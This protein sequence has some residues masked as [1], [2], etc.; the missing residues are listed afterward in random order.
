MHQYHPLTVVLVR[1]NWRSH[2]SSQFCFTLYF[3]S[4]SLDTIAM[5]NGIIFANSETNSICAQ[6]SVL[7]IFREI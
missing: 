1:Y 7:S 2:H 3:G 4:M 6:N 5:K